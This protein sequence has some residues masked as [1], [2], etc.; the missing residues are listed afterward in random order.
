MASIR[1]YGEDKNSH[2]SRHRVQCSR[3]AH[4]AVVV[5][6]KKKKTVNVIINRNHFSI[7]HLQRILQSPL[8]SFNTVQDGD[9]NMDV[10]V[11]QA[12]AQFTKF[13]L[14]IRAAPAAG[15]GSGAAGTCCSQS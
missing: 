7:N 15:V 2:V 14:L 13:T 9:E 4:N 1:C 10:D 8:S 12:S 5:E 3:D 6:Y 11:F